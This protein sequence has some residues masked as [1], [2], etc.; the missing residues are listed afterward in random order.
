MPP[1]CFLAHP[2]SAFSFCGSL[3]LTACCGSF[4]GSFSA[5][6]PHP[7]KKQGWFSLKEKF[8]QV[9]TQGDCS[10]L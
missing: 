8:L 3:G 9:N 5:C 6:V 2:H 4:F 7:E 10:L 1:T